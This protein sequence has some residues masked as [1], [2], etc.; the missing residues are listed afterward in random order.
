VF[1]TLRQ[2]ARG[3]AGPL[4]DAGALEA[5]LLPDGH[6]ALL[7]ADADPTATWQIL[8]CTPHDGCVV[9]AEL[10][11]ASWVTRIEPTWL[12]RQD[13]EVPV[14]LERQGEPP[15]EPLRGWILFC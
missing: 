12:A 2:S 7:G 13:R 1:D 9:R 6:V 15:R 10:A 3:A 14:T 11:G 8:G 5:H 4:H